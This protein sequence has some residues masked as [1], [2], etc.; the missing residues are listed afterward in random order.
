MV[1]LALAAAAQ[2]PVPKSRLRG[3]CR[4]LMGWDRTAQSPN[5]RMHRKAPFENGQLIVLEQATIVQLD[6]Q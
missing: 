6:Q 1:F 5:Q 4:S 2:A 3:A